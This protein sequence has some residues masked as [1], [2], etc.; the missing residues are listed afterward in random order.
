[1]FKSFG[2]GQ[3]YFSLY[4]IGMVCLK[5]I[6]FF[7]EV[8]LRVSMGLQFFFHIFTQQYLQI[9]TQSSKKIFF[10]RSLCSFELLAHYQKFTNRSSSLILLKLGNV[11]LSFE[12]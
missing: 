4:V 12:R 6:C 8:S 5:Q 7:L 11:F 3:K 10:S 9:V 2:P 1:M